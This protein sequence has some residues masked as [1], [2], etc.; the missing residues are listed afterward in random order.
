MVKGYYTLNDKKTKAEPEKN[1][2]FAIFFVV[3][4]T[5]GARNHILE[6]AEKN[7]GNWGLGK[8]KSKAEP[9]LNLSQEKY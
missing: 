6:I 8:N 4:M 3:V 7:I 9:V 1:L 2:G 5:Y